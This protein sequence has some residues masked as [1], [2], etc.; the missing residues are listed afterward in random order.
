M[1]EFSGTLI[2]RR[3]ERTHLFLVAALSF[4]RASTPVRVRN[5]SAT[6]A[7]VEGASLP[8]AGTAVFLRRGEREAAGTI[9]WLEP[10]KAGLRFAGLV[11]VQAWLP[12]KGSKRQTEVDRIAFG[13]KHS[14]PPTAAIAAPPPGPSAMPVGAVVAELMALRADLE[15]LG[16]K[17]AGD[18]VVLASHP[19]V[20]FLDAAGQRIARIVA[21][22]RP[23]TN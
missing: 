16:D 21:A 20:Q 22:L 12:A 3:T 4:A 15:R 2:D 8:P 13:L 18:A 7:L 17:L 14:T 11:D 9:I 10:G 19:E 1:N 23:V 6:G 5:L